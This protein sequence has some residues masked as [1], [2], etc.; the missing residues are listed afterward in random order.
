MYNIVFGLPGTGKS[1][2]VQKNKV[3]ATLDLGNIPDDAKK[4]VNP[5]AAKFTSAL[6]KIPINHSL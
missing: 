2:F 5:R 3:N 4:I 1:T 6:F